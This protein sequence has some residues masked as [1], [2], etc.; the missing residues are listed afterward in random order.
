[1]R[2]KGGVDMGM[3][4]R[5]IWCLMLQMLATCMLISLRMALPPPR[6][7]ALAESE[8]VFAV[9]VLPPVTPEPS[10]AP[11]PPPSPTPTP[12]AED[13]LL[14]VE[15]IRDTP[16]PD[17]GKRILIYHTHTWEAY[18]QEEGARYAETEK[19]RTKDD[20]FNVV[21]VGRALTAHLTALGFTV[22]H[23]TTAFEPPNLDDAYARSLVMLEQRL[24]AGET[25]D[26]YID[27]HRDALADASTIRRTV[28]TSGGD[29]ARFMVLVGKGTTGGYA[30]RPDWEQNLLVAQ[31]ITDAL[32]AQIDGLAR[33]VKIKTGRFN[34]HIDDCCVLIECGVN[35]NT[36][37][38]VLLG[39]PYLAQAVFDALT[40]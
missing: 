32:N 24:A 7:G 25:Y 27:L 30:E 19:W 5:A 28:P 36:L 34:Q 31:R 26:L 12:A 3:K 22:V 38:E 37:D 4:E 10:A 14:Q 2:A 11:T 33:D 8:P 29:A 35:T 40:P 18:Q 9:E 21:A 13:V 1:M 23:D 17:T 6:S 15:V 16:D 39:V 20:A